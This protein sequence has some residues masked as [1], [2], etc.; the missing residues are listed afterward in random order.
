MLDMQPDQRSRDPAHL[1]AARRTA[2]AFAP[3]TASRNGRA[4]TGAA[5]RPSSVARVVTLGPYIACLEPLSARTNAPSNVIP[6]KAPLAREY[7]RIIVFSFT[8]VFSDECRPKGPTAADASLPISNLLESS[9]CMP[10]SLLKTMTRSTAS[11][12]ICVPQLPPPIW[13]NAG[14]LQ[15]FAVRQVAT[16]LPSSAPNTNPPFIKW[17]I[18]ATHFAF[19]IVQSG[20]RWSGA[21][22]IS[23]STAA[24][25][26]S[27]LTASWRSDPAQ[28]SVPKLRVAS[29]HISAFIGVASFPLLLRRFSRL[30][31]GAVHAH[32]NPSRHASAPLQLQG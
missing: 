11:T 30:V 22:I 14:A 3:L 7:V 24:D 21:F 19:F 28:H 18:T 32:T 6:R 26:F 4:A 25:L 23:C 15:P 9:F 10:F 5:T 17:G 16:P 13:M 27:R 8:S 31:L 12:P 2:W 29:K 1:L 20:M